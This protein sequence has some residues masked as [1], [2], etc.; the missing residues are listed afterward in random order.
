MSLTASPTNVLDHASLHATTQDWL[1]SLKE[2]LGKA[3]C[4]HVKGLA[5]KTPRIFEVDEDVDLRALDVKDAQKLIFGRTFDVTS[6]WDEA[7]SEGLSYQDAEFVQTSLT[8][9]MSGDFSEEIECLAEAM[10]L[11]VD[12]LLK[13]LKG[14]DSLQCVELDIILHSMRYRYKGAVAAMAPF[15]DFNLDPRAGDSLFLGLRD[16]RIPLMDYLQVASESLDQ[17]DR[18]TSDNGGPGEED[19]RIW[20]MKNFKPEADESWSSIYS[21]HVV[22]SHENFSK[23]TNLSAVS[24]ANGGPVISGEDLIALILDQYG[25]SELYLHVTVGASTIQDLGRLASRHD[26]AREGDFKL[27]VA[28]G[29]LSTESCPTSGLPWASQLLSSVE[30]AASEFSILKEAPECRGEDD[31]RF[32][33]ADDVRVRLYDVGV[34]QRTAGRCGEP[35]NPMLAEDARCIEGCLSIMHAAP[36]WASALA[37]MGVPAFDCEPVR[38]VLEQKKIDFPTASVRM[39]APDG[40]DEPSAGLEAAVR[41]LR[42]LAHRGDG[43][44]S[45]KKSA[46]ADLVHWLIDCGHGPCLSLP[47]SAQRSLFENAVLSQNSGILDRLLNLA[48]DRFG[49]EAH[50][51]LCQSLMPICVGHVAKAALPV[52]VDHGTSPEGWDSTV[53]RKRT[54]CLADPKK[55][56]HRLQDIVDFQTALRAHQARQAA[57]AS[58]WALDCCPSP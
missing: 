20:G 45:V 15:I 11:E 42:V 56:E 34:A 33:L 41:A 8:D 26:L 39:D 4:C 53:E 28:S 3:V 24:H 1:E 31:I 36:Y 38:S 50:Q 48:I 51:H 7:S 12:D 49:T 10:G 17:M 27:R 40:L 13:N 22:R 43:D 5:E 14:D 54:Q 16:L 55:S 52:L 21:E 46:T 57:L 37:V 32:T 58:L 23:R 18:R 30:V 2:R 25:H 35:M 47:L 29:Y 6:S 44:G 9:Q 19:L